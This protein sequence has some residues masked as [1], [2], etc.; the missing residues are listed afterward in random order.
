[1]IEF[2]ELFKP[3]RK[4]KKIKPPRPAF[5]RRP[6]AQRTG[7]LARVAG[8]KTEWAWS[9]GPATTQVAWPERGGACAPPVVTPR[10]PRA[11]WRSRRQCCRGPT[12]VRCGSGEPAMKCGGA[13]QH[14]DGGS[15]PR[16]CG[17]GAV[18]EASDATVV[19]W[20]PAVGPIA[21]GG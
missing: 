17:D 5:G 16:R 6:H 20:W 10:W 7:G 3:I 13:G 18:V 19:L 11:R 2:L 21:Q 1:L 4:R 14:K 12:T 9:C 15:S 8:H